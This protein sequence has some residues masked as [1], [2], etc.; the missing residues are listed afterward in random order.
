MYLFQDICIN[1][2]TAGTGRAESYVRAISK[3]NLIYCCRCPVNLDNI[4]V[5]SI[6]RVWHSL[7]LQKVFNDFWFI[8][9]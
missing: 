7:S 5:V 3:K 6:N 9:R 8:Y 4:E 2:Q 1:Q